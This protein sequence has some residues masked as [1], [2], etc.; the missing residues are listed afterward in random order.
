[1]LRIHKIYYKTQN[2]TF[3]LAHSMFW[4]SVVTKYSC[5]VV[6]FLSKHRI[7]QTTVQLL[8]QLCTDAGKYVDVPFSLQYAQP[9]YHAKI[10]TVTG[11]VQ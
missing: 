11:Y 10:V 7:E 6:A 9:W 8:I 4:L 1:M 5:F 2:G 3:T